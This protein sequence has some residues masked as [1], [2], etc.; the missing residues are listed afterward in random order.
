M[1][2][3]FRS[4][5]PALAVVVLCAAL[6]A[7]TAGSDDG[8]DGSATGEGSADTAAADAEQQ[9]TPVAAAIAGDQR[10][11]TFSDLLV[12]AGWD[13][14]LGADGPVTVLVPTDEAFSAVPP[15][16][17]EE[18]GSDPGGSLPDLLGLHV[19]DGKLGTADLEGL[20]GQPVDTYSGKV[21]ILVDGAGD[22]AIDGATII[23]PDIDGG[24][25]VI[26]VIDAVILEA[27]A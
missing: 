9:Q 14:T 23:D 4:F 1:G 11:S 20:N 21:P 3:A 10:L 27:T 12:A 13:H 16:I 25:S 6:G 7:C 19:I 8:D 17:V 26:H 24:G 22:V 18:L 2:S 15:E 5:R